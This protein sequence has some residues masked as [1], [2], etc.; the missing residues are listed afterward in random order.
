MTVRL[1]T[2]GDAAE[3]ARVLREAFADFERLYTRAAFA[4]TTPPAETIGQRVAEGPTW[5][6]L[7][8]DRVVG[9]V[10][11]I[12]REDG[13]YVRSTAVAPDGRGRGV[14]RE[15]MGQVE[16]FARS[17]GA[18]RIYLS[19]TPMLFD[20]IRLYESLGFRRTGEPPHDL[21]GTPLFTMA[22]ALG[23]S[24]ADPR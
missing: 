2:R 1:A 23:A 15:L 7:R 22:K 4:A 19:T 5:V 6:A 13:V 16:L 10:S 24:R 9:T 20:A 18:T 12:R 14:A 17:A 3:V 8:G 21:H 11:A